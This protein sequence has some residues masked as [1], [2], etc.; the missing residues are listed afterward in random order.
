[1]YRFHEETNRTCMLEMGAG[2]KDGTVK[3]VDL[4]NFAFFKN[5]QT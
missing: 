3:D 2:Q 5:A 4:V 1:M